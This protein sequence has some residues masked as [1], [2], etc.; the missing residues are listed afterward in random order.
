MQN[1]YIIYI[2]SYVKCNR[3]A[4][5]S[6]IWVTSCNIISHLLVPKRRGLSYGPNFRKPL[7]QWNCLIDIVRLNDYLRK[8]SWKKLYGFKMAAILLI[9]LSRDCAIPRKWNTFP[10]THIWMKFGRSSIETHNLKLSFECFNLGNFTGK[11]VFYHMT[12]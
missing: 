3:K 12:K 2:S 7:S 5:I 4:L 11:N 10:K 6:N 8:K 1:I 9:Y